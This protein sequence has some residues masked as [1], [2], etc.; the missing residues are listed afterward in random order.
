MEGAR[1]AFGRTLV[2]HQP[3]PAIGSELLLQ[4][5]HQP[6]L[7]DSRLAREPDDLTLTA[8]RQTP[9]VEQ[10]VELLSSSDQG[11][12]LRSVQCLEPAL[13]R[14][15]HPEPDG[16]AR[17]CRSPCGRTGASSRH[18]NRSPIRR[19]VLSAINTVPGSAM[20]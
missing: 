14:P 7:S 8:L 3:M 1:G 20:S 12:E 18:S 10:Q 15:A 4:R 6:R 13:A 16:F 19:R 5:L 2:D 11:R 9:A 17:P